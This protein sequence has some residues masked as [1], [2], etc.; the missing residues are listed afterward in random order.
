MPAHNPL[1][2]PQPGEIVAPKSEERASTRLSRKRKRRISTTEKPTKLT[3]TV[4]KQRTA[5]EEDDLD[6]SMGINKSFAHMDSR[7]LADY[8][9]QR[10][11]KF[12][13]DLSSVE[14]ED[15]CISGNYAIA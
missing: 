11:R 15:R 8:V 14:L 7:L 5:A 10:I 1:H 9:A 12:E 6:L 13:S 4:K 3:E 2:E